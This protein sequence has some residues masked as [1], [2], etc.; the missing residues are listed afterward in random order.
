MRIDT[1]QGIIQVLV[2]TVTGLQIAETSVW[3]CSCYFKLAVLDYATSSE[4][5]RN[6]G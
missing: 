3:M 2:I 5:G 6:T 4:G 1:R